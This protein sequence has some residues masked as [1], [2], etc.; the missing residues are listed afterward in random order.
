MIRVEP[1]PEI[2]EDFKEIWARLAGI[3]VETRGD[4]DELKYLYGSDD[5]VKFLDDLAPAFFIRHREILVN[6]VILSLAQLTDAKQSGGQ[7]NLTYARLMDGLPEDNEHQSLRA[8]LSRRGEEIKLAAKSI[9][10][11]RHKGLAHYD[12]IR[13]LTRS[14]ELGKD[15]T[16]ES[17]EVLLSKVADFLRA[18]HDFFSPHVETTLEF[19]PLFGNAEDLIERI[20]L[21]K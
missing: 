4:L 6:Q 2:P 19:I 8:D 10:N 21:V 3:L 20:K 17:I 15:I 13:C 1:G 14:T 16:V 7:D 18:F 9:R 12:L 5:M 11:Y